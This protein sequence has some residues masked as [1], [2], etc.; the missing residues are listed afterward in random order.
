MQVRAVGTVAGLLACCVFWRAAQGQQPAATLNSDAL[1]QVSQMLQDARDEVRKHYY[2]AKF[3]GL[4]WDAR[5]KEYAAMLPKAHN[6]GEGFR[7]IAAFLDGLKDSHVYFIP[8]ERQNRYDD[9][10]QFSLVGDRCFITQVR[11]KSDADAKLH[12]GDEVLTMDGFNIN[13]D[14]Y[15]DQRYFFRILSPMGGAQM[16]LRAPDGT[17]KT[18]V[19]QH[20]VKIGKAMLD[21]TDDEGTTDFESL[22]RRSENSH[23]ASQARIPPHDTHDDNV[24]RKVICFPR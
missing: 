1:Y 23:H 9:G 10:Y 15:Q 24:P 19:V 14:D 16:A 17:Q 5:Y 7:V 22:V 18:V 12:I 3:N 4:D 8:P 2:D 13:R 21:L 6:L 20:S 11:P